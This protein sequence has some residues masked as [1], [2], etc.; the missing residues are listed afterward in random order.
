MS[1]GIFIRSLFGRYEYYIC[2]AY[3]SFYFDLDSF[4]S[5]VHAWH[6]NAARIL[7]IGCGEGAVTE[8]LKGAYPQAKIT[9]IDVSPRLGRLYEGSRQGVQFIKYHAEEIAAAEPGQYDLAV[10][11]DVLHHVPQH[12]RRE[13]LGSIR[14]ALAPDGILIFK[15]WERNF[16]PIHWL[17]YASD[18]WLTGDRVGY[19]TRGEMREH[20]KRGFGD[21]ALIAE[22]RFAP[23]H[24]N[25]ATLVQP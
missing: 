23:W 17:C 8:R 24:N 11:C 19:M 10:L 15:E 9:A 7:E 3:R 25:I 5:C 18:R 6:P 21:A 12:S 16:T 20:L 2:D 13:L 22:S 14:K 4:V 1:L